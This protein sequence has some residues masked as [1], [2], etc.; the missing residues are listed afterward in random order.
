HAARDDVARIR[1]HFEEADRAD[2]TR[3]MRPRDPVDLGHCLRRADE[4]VAPSDHWR[5]AGMRVLARER[6]FEP[7]NALHA[8]DHADLLVFALEDRALLD[9]QL[10]ER[11]EFA[12][13]AAL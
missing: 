9:V 4:R 3:R 12:G 7:A 10:E 13:A 8:G 6:A 2:R 5:R 1:R 11:G